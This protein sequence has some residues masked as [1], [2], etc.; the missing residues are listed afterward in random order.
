MPLLSSQTHPASPLRKNPIRSLLS[1]TW[2]SKAT[3][4]FLAVSVSIFLF[5]LQG[6]WDMGISFTKAEVE[7]PRQ[8]RP[9]LK[10]TS[11]IGVSIEEDEDRPL[12]LYAYHETQNA[13]RNAQFFITHGLHAHADFIFILNGEANPKFV[14]SIPQ[15]DNIQIIQRDNTCFDLGSYA[16]VLTRNNSKLVKKY[17]RFILMNAS[18]RGPF[19]PTWSRECWSDAILS[20][21]TD[22]NKLVGLT[23]NCRPVRH[24]QSMMFATDRTGLTLLLDKI[25]TCFSNFRAAVKVETECTAHILESGYN[26]T[27]LMTS[28]ST[29]KDYATTCTHDDVLHPDTYFKTTIHPYDIM[30]QKANRKLAPE[31]LVQL[32]KWH[33]DAG[34]SSWAACSRA[35]KIK[36][37]LRIMKKNGYD[38]DFDL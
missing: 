29:K 4:C 33:D 5:L 8:D 1:I 18:L 14:K 15:A 21:V 30:F 17:N 36:K 35:Y 9:P 27:A 23:Y 25:G 26:V 24:V 37:A 13:H 32:T 16:E 11:G 22:T 31:V 2:A 12:I 6:S 7:K 38:L 28:F 19:L 3:I 20:K 10:G 34:Y